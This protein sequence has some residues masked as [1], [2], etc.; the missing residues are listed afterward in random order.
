VNVPMSY[1][2]GD[3]DYECVFREILLPVAD[4]YKPEWILV[5]AGFDIH[6]SDPLGGMTVSE[7]GFAMMTRMLLDMGAKHCGGKVLFALEGGY[8][9]TGLANSTKAVIMEM[10]E[11]PLYAPR[12]KDNLSAGILQTV[13]RV[14]QVLKP[15]WGNL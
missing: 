9:L 15:Y 11:T 2:M 3:Q 13:A 7:G 4:Q 6:H 10:K 8:D 14:K 12:E 5:S 1:G